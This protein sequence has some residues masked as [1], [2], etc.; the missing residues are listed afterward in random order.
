MPV[1]TGASINIPSSGSYV[2]LVRCLDTTSPQASGNTTL[3]V[4]TKTKGAID[5]V[6]PDNITVSIKCGDKVSSLNSI[7]PTILAGADNN[8]EV[9]DFWPTFTFLNHMTRVWEV[10]C[11]V[12]GNN[13]V[14]YDLVAEITV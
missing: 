5:L 1:S 9:G 4:Y 2:L 12:G 6:S 10:T 8:I 11:E 7:T 14:P 3:I 13:E